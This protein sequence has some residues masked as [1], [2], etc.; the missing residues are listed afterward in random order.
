MRQKARYCGN[1]V[2]VQMKRVIK[3]Q[4]QNVYFNL[5]LYNNYEEFKLL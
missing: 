1:K 5:L 2:I 4:K 3:F